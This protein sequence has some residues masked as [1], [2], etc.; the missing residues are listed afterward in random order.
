[1]HINEIL[2]KYRF[3][4][5]T[6]PLFVGI[7]ELYPPQQMAL[8][9]GVLEGKNLLL[10]VPTAAGK[11]L[12]AE[13]SMLAALYRHAGRCLYIVP[14][15]ALANEKY[16]DFRK[17]YTPLDIKVG[18]ATGDLNGNDPYLSNYQII[19]ATAEKVDALLRSRADWLMQNLRVIVLDE[20]H[21]LNDGS[22]G[23]TLE[24]LAARLKQLNPQAQILALS[25]T[26]GNAPDMAQW[27]NAAL[28]TSTWRPIPLHEGIYYHSAI[29]FIHHPQKLITEQADEPHVRLALDTL[30][31]G[32]QVL[33]FVN[34][35][36]SAEAA[37]RQLCAAVAGTLTSMDKDR[38]A[39]I[40]KEAIGAASSATKVCRQLSDVIRHGVAFHHAGLKSEQRQL[41]EDHFRQNHIKV[42]CATPT[43]AAGVNLPARRAIIRDIKRFETGL[44]ASFIPASEY[45]QCAGRAGRPQYDTYGEAVLIAKSD[46]EKTLLMDRYIKAAPE[47]VIS[48]LSDETVLRTHILASIAGGYV[49]DV[50]ATLAFLSHTFMAHQHTHPNLLEMI[51]QIFDFLQQEGFIEKEGFRFLATPF[52][53]CTSRLYIDP[54]S[55]LTLRKGLVKMAQGKSFSPI[56][57]LHLIGCCPDSPLLKFRN[58]EVDE[59][60]RF[61]AACEDELVV[62]ANDLDDLND[63]QFNLSVI[64]TAMMLNQW[65]AE[66]T[67]EQICDQFSIGPGDV[68]RH[69]ESARW[70]LH[71]AITF[72][73]LFHFRSLTFP[74]ATLRDRIQYGIKEELIP[75]TR[76]KGIG[77]IRARQLYQNGFRTLADFKRVTIDDLAQIDKIGRTLAQEILSQIG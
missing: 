71:A 8:D 69:N 31:G 48:K 43:L 30:R 32:G 3:P 41:I 72:A 15:R 5:T 68:Y 16:Q 52:G 47:P 28:V 66:H 6:V 26:I 65:I 70:L 58:N 77:R 42:L 62:S 1:M 57:V 7:D 53:Q 61:A 25:A 19:V 54:V 10:S 17:K 40:A 75:L 44:T 46:S 73:D 64:K 67:E 23:P 22:R 13:L 14:L 74:L 36:R 50:Q 12:I 2:T 33:T 63:Y 60:N 39:M 11:T 9:T 55:S 59:L 51:S 37:S 20:I 35:R 45:K 56:G 21:F 27:L 76:L 18:L 38:L 49:H 24:I 29:T 34:S 4:P